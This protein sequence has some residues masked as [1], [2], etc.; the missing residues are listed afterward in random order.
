MPEEST[1]TQKKS[2]GEHL[3]HYFW[4]A[5]RVALLS[6]CGLT[7]LLYLIQTKLMFPG[8]GP[9]ERNPASLG[10]AFEEI[11]DPVPGG[12]T[13][14]WY[15]PLEKARGVVLFSHG[16]GENVSDALEHVRLF[17]ELGFSALVYDYGGYG[18][19]TGKP[20]E[21]R[22]YED[23]RAMWRFLVEQ[24]KVA[25]EH[26]VLWGRSL[27]G[28][29]VSQLASEVKPGA[30]ILE[31]TFSSGV[32]ITKETFPYLPVRLLLRDRFDNI[33]K[34]PLFK[35]PLMIIHSRNDTLV[36]EH[37]GKALFDAAHEPKK[38]VETRGDH[39]EGLFVS[40][41]TYKQALNDFLTPLFPT[42]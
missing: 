29:P 34:V 33:K 16:N 19:S 2:R 38:F 11:L 10:W 42:P 17:R 32:D 23:I 6:Y 18:K 7:L 9:L 8:A 13:H 14:G 39:N 28:G 36:P 27:G 5:L 35:A 24:K 30:I 3:K 20:S 1:D 15:I 22:V 31:S 37:H 25:P 40:W 26:I 21:Q 12:E 41:D 4:L